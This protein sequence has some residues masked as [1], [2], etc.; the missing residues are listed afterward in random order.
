RLPTAPPVPYTTLFRSPG[1]GRR[2]PAA[3]PAQSRRTG[4]DSRGSR[5]PSVQGGN[6]RA[7]PV[8]RSREMPI[9]ATQAYDDNNI[10]ARIIRGERSEEHTSELQSR[11]HLV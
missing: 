7:S 2:P 6:E 9:D 1:R 5:R 8:K 11:G 10:F 3:R 4:S